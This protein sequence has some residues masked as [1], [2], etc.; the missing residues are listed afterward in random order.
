[1]VCQPQE[2]SIY[3]PLFRIEYGS[4]VRASDKSSEGL[5]LDHRAGNQT[6]SHRSV[7]LKFDTPSL[8]L[9]QLRTVRP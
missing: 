6:A 2:T 4:L 1:M 3:Q 8:L 9:A 5:A 7:L